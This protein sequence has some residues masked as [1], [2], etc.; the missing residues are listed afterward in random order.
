MRINKKYD[1]FVNENMEMAKSI[2]A[3]KMDAFDKLKTLLSKNIG[4][5]GIVTITAV[6]VERSGAKSVIADGVEI[7][8]DEEISEPY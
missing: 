5:I 7:E 4:Y 1:N 8:F 6:S 2:I 3:K